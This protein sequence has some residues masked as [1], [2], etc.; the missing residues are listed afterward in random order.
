MENTNEILVISNEL[1]KQVN[2]S[3]T[4]EQLEK[5][6]AEALALKVESVDDL[7]GYG[8][9]KAKRNEI[10]KIRT[11]L[12]KERVKIKEEA[13][14][15]VKY[16]DSTARTIRT[17][18][19]DIESTL[20]QQEL[21]VENE[22]ARKKAEHEESQKRK[23]AERVQILRQ[24]RFDVKFEDLET[25]TNLSD[26]DFKALVGKAYE[27]FQQELAQEEQA[28]KD[29]EA[30]ALRIKELE[31]ESKK[32]DAELK[33]MQDKIAEMD[34]V[35]NEEARKRADEDRA[36]AEAIAKVEREKAQEQERLR[37]AEQEKARAELAEQKR[38]ADEAEAKR[39]EVERIAQKEKEQAQRK[40]QEQEAENERLRQ[41]EELRL[42][43][44]AELEI[45]RQQEWRVIC[46]VAEAQKVQPKLLEMAKKN[47]LT[48]QAC[49]VEIARLVEELANLV[50]NIEA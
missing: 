3:I 14:A 36:R 17:R 33:A 21:I 6:T 45:K 42:K 38:I 48:L 20:K 34:R 35:A 43:R 28:K 24:Y 9:C 46:E 8:A 12:D 2:Y 5:I 50:E 27:S 40:L 23:Q 11:G 15:F 41:A 25:L 31:A 47:F 44:E 32:K 16:V 4:E 19:E 37:L 13:Q 7:K 29:R 30:E 18:L 26:E 49:W 22:I 10:V 39:L 1:K